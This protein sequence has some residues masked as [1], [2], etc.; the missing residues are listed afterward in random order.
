[1]FNKDTLE[2]EKINMSTQFYGFNTREGQIEQFSQSK[3]VSTNDQSFMIS[4]DDNRIKQIVF[5]LFS[6]SMKMA[7]QGDNIVIKCQNVMSR[8]K[9][10]KTYKYSSQGRKTKVSY[11]LSINKG[12]L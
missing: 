9:K 5:N 6:I 4:G 2:K 10:K 8:K 12:Q 3:Q 7:D 1:M 11:G